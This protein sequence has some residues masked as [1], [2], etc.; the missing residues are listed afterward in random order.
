MG[1]S[2]TEI[3]PRHTANGEALSAIVGVRAGATGGA[4]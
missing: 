4:A 1:H 2:A 3:N